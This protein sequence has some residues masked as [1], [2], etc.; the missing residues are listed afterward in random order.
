MWSP[1]S[2]TALVV[3][4]RISLGSVPA[5]SDAPWSDMSDWVLRLAR[6]VLLRHE[7]K[8]AVRERRKTRSRKR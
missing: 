2:G 1:S 5:R 8:E 6:Y 7:F 4:D 3:N